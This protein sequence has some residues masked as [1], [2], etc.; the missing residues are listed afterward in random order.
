MHTNHVTYNYIINGLPRLVTLYRIT[1]GII[2][3]VSTH[4]LWRCGDGEDQICHT[5]PTPPNV[6]NALKEP[7]G[8]GLLP[9]LTTG[10][11][12]IAFI[13]QE[14]ET[15]GLEGEG[16]RGGEEGRARE[17]GEGERGRGGREGEGREG[18]GRRQVRKEAGE[19]GEKGREGEGREG[20]EV[21]EGREKMQG[22]R[23][24]SRRGRERGGR[25]V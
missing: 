19:E 16:R 12:S 7:K 14:Q 25:M 5:L 9:S 3:R 17:E 4:T 13:I 22:K 21:R 15:R 10:E 2:Q 8:C 18:K 11:G 1:Y 23:G 6:G 20:R 24:E